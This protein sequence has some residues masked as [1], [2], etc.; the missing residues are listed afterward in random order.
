MNTVVFVLMVWSYSGHWQPTIEFTTAD[1][2]ATAA[3][4]MAA[5]IDKNASWGQLHKNLWCARIEK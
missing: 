4:A 5:Q 3:V 1:K 2:C